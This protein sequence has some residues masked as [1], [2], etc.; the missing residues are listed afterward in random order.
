MSKLSDLPNSNLLPGFSRFWKI[1]SNS[2]G[3]KGNQ[4]EA[5]NE[6][7]RLQ[8]EGHEDELISLYLL[9]LRDKEQCASAGYRWDP[10]K[11]I[12]RWLKYRAWEDSVGDSQEPQESRPVSPEEAQEAFKVLRGGGK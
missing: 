5:H 10:F 7:K 12:C 6:W 1:T 4:V 8:L 2:Y 11:H 3:K 9:Q